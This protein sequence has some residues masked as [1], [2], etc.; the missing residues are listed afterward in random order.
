MIELPSDIDLVN[1]EF[2]QAWNLIRHTNRS[3]FLTGKAGTGKSTFL[4]YIC[5]HTK[6]N[7]VVLAPTGIA[8]VNVGGVTLHS[9]FQIPMRPV[10]PDDVEYSVGNIRRKLK[11]SKEK[12]KLIKALE[13]VIIDEISMVRPDTIDFIDR[14]LR[15]Y[16]DNKREPFGG[17]QLLLVGDIFQLEPVITSDT[18]TILSH[19]YKNFFFFNAKAYENVNLVAIELKKIYRQKEQKFVEILDRIRLNKATAD[20][21]QIINRQ[22]D[23]EDTSSKEDFTITL[24]SKRD[25]VD[26]INNKELDALPGDEITFHG[27]IEGDFPDRLLPT[28]KDLILK[29]N[30]Q[31]ILIKNDKEKRW[32]NGT[33]AKI[34]NLSD[35]ALMIEL[36]SGDVHTLTPEIWEN[37]KYTYNESTRKIE[38][39]I[40]GKFTQFPVKAAWALTVHKSQGLTFNRVVIDLG[41]GAFSSGQAYVA[42][43]RCSTLSGITLRSKLSPR[44]I[45]LNRAVI[46]FSNKFN[47]ICLINNALDSARADILYQ[48]AYD[49]FK[50]MKFDVAINKFSEALALRNDINNPVIRRFLSVKLSV[51]RQQKQEIDNLRQERIA[52]AKEYIDMGGECL[53]IPDA[54]IAALSNFEKALRLDPGNID[55]LYGKAIALRD[56]NNTDD[57]IN[58]VKQLLQL[59]PKFYPAMCMLASCYLSSDA[60]DKALMAA[61]NALKV[62]KTDPE[63]H[64]LIAEISDKLGL[65]DLAEKH[66]LLAEKYRSRK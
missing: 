1:H 27:C 19:Y 37:I 38:E 35:E 50:E 65:E 58:V 47:D 28:D 8:A 36:E 32:V 26:A 34:H 66:R 11:F 61:M 3:I 10:P 21:L 30:A 41:E 12:I 23:A 29:K 39:E 22:Y 24:A 15:S 40:L 45:I 4:R 14:V 6:K 42:L 16:S 13:L 62:R 51:I 63:L 2:I 59:K 44:D 49:N 54:T 52:L 64:Y 20:D 7:H 46:D 31:I 43:S 25:I 57:A 9:F 55:A 33:I 53:Q 5:E 56:S 60:T 17:K 48:E 18:R